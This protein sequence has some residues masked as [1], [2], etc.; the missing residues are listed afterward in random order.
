M[1]CYAYCQGRDL[2]TGTQL[3]PHFSAVLHVKTPGESSL[4]TFSP[5]YHYPF[6]SL[7]LQWL[8][9]RSMLLIPVANSLFPSGLT[10]LPHLTQTVRPS[11]LKQFLLLLHVPPLLLPYWVNC[12][13]SPADPFYSLQFVV[14]V[15]LLCSWLS[16]LLYTIFQGTSSRLV[17]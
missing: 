2:D 6:H 5:I 17:L 13:V 8:L 14:N 12:S 9:S 16:S 1:R 4:D 10:S 7:P 11:S 3:S 15:T